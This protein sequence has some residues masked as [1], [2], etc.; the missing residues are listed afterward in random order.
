MNT[1]EQK[2]NHGLNLLLAIEFARVYGTS[3][4]AAIQRCAK[5]VRDETKDERMHVY[6]KRLIAE[7]NQAR[8]TSVVSLWRGMFDEGL[9]STAPHKEYG[10]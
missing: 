7:S 8:V 3:Q 4:G 5:R 6:A 2:Y 1:A 10:Q 9:V